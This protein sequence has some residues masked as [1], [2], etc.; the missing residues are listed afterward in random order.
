MN[1]IK[2]REIVKNNKGK[3]FSLSTN[4]DICDLL[5]SKG[6]LEAHEKAEGLVRALEILAN[7]KFH[8]CS[9]KFIGECECEKTFSKLALDQWRGEG[10]N[11]NIVER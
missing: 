7:G 4:N 11:E 8:T 9:E 1:I 10:R 3:I 2:A 5:F 6:F